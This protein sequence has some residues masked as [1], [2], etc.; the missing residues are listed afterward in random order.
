MTYYFNQ[1]DLEKYLA[2]YKELKNI[3][4]ELLKENKLANN[5]DLYEQYMSKIQTYYFDENIEYAKIFAKTKEE[6][7]EKTREY[8]NDIYCLDEGYY[9]EDELL[10]YEKALQ[11]AYIN[12]IGQGYYQIYNSIGYG[13]YISVHRIDEM[14][15]IALGNAMEKFEFND[16]VWEYICEHSDDI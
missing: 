5:Y 9:D 7:I 1:S 4:K 3:E 2:E 11:E 12:F 10:E 14:L 8:I 15:Q 6:L 13:G 16:E